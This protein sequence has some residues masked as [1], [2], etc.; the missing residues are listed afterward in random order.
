MR[1]S[2]RASDHVLRAVSDL[3]IAC[4]VFVESFCSITRGNDRE[5]G[6][7]ISA[8]DSNVSQQP[9]MQLLCIECSYSLVLSGCLL[10]LAWQRYV[11]R[12]T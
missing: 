9:V 4:S 3:A 7:R 10:A 8:G 12:G 5:T 1:A 6:G 11:A 2:A